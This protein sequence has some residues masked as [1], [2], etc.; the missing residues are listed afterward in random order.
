[1]FAWVIG[2]KARLADRP[3]MDASRSRRGTTAS[4]WECPFIGVLE[5]SLPASVSGVGGWRLP[6]GNDGTL[7]Q[8]A[9]S[10]AH[11]G[12]ASLEIR[13]ALSRAS[14]TGV[15][16]LAGASFSPGDEHI[17]RVSM[18]SSHDSAAAQEELDAS[19]A[20]TL[21]GHAA[22]ASEVL[23]EAVGAGY[24][25]VLHDLEGS[26]FVVRSVPSGEDVAF[27]E[28][29]FE[30]GMCEWLP[31]GKA[32]GRRRGG[33]AGGGGRCSGGALDFFHTFTHEEHR[34]KV[35]AVHCGRSCE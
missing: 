18:A 26:K 7:A 19:N 20:S 32:G 21:A 4:A 24:S 8:R 6:A 25:G 10:G 3:Q 35:C 16:E 27:V 9:A 29:S 17:S 34:G 31:A 33:F 15:C 5:G 14:E 11:L 12:G 2:A 13:S 30:G 28:Y 22:G 1:V 23:S